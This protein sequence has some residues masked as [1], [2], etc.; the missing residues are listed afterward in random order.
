MLRPSTGKPE[1][2]VG[3]EEAMGPAIDWTYESDHAL[4]IASPQ[5]REKFREAARTH[6][7]RYDDGDPNDALEVERTAALAWRFH[8]MG[9]GLRAYPCSTTKVLPTRRFSA[10]CGRSPTCM[11]AEDT[12]ARGPLGGDKEA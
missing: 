1:A 4:F 3:I 2:K 5:M 9:L 8:A 7:R 11:R 10:I 12:H 6:M